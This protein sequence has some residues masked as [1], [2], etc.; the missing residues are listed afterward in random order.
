MRNSRPFIAAGFLFFA[1]LPDV[2]LAA[3][4]TTTFPVTATVQNVCSVT[5]SGLAFGS[6]DPT[7]N[8]DLDASTTLSVLCTTGTSFTVGL[9]AGNAPSATVSSRAM[10][11][12]GNQLSYAL[13]TDSGRTSNWGNT[14]GSDTPAAQ[15]AGTSATVMT[16]FGRVAKRQNVPTG[17]YADTITVT[18][19]Y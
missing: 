19:N 10:V 16:V 2:S 4:A 6:Y 9:N 12:G 3:T 17:S 8:T 13:Y 5:A 7:S 1:L 14:P 11:N 15:V 18:A